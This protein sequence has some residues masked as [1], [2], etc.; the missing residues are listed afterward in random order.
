MSG[1]AQG[2][3]ALPKRKSAVA[4]HPP[5]LPRFRG[6]LMSVCLGGSG[7][8]DA[9]PQTSS[10]PQTV[11]K[12]ERVPGRPALGWRPGAARE[13]VPLAMPSGS[14][15][16]AGVGRGGRR[17]PRGPRFE[18]HPDCITYRLRLFSSLSKVRA[19]LTRSVLRALAI[20]VSSCGIAGGGRRCPLGSW[21]PEAPRC[22]PEPQ[23]CV[24]GADA[25]DSKWGFDVW[26][27]GA[28][29]SVSRVFNWI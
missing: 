12:L 20:L 22:F 15:P 25:A 3:R 13:P 29:F 28:V 1:P 19:N 26:L 17:G 7:S 14:V 2:W 21:P 9:P 8:G 11:C 18:V 6:S 16:G 5:R 27:L 10:H 4:R 23:A 24:P